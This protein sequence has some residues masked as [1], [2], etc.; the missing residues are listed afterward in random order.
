MKG[1]IIR[2]HVMHEKFLS[3]GDEAK[4]NWFIKLTC[5]QLTSS[6]GLS[7]SIGSA[8]EERTEFE[9]ALRNCLFWN[10]SKRF[11]FLI[12]LPVS[13]LICNP[14]SNLGYNQDVVDPYWAHLK[15]FSWKLKVN[16][17]TTLRIRKSKYIGIEIKTFSLNTDKLTSNEMIL[18]TRSLLQGIHGFR[19]SSGSACRIFLSHFFHLSWPFLDGKRKRPLSPL[20][21][22]VQF[23]TQQEC[24][25]VKS[26]EVDQCWLSRSTDRELKDCF[27]PRNPGNNCGKM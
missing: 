2:S 23:I 19:R 12:C 14:Y 20:H 3:T 16:Y 7:T 1:Q 24:T 17:T 25:I 9:A 26:R 27:L 11:I 5:W 10:L 6:K 13:L 21:L 8:V 18:Q 15:K 22:A 4:G